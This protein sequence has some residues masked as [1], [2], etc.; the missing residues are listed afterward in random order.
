MLTLALNLV[1]FFRDKVSV[2]FPGWPVTQYVDQAGPELTCLCF[3]RAGNK[4]R[5]HHTQ[6][7]LFSFEKRHCQATQAGL[8]P[9]MLLHRLPNGDSVSRACVTLLSGNL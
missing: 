5:S 4:G 8:K 9:Q 1:N 7:I 2:C 3:P 6:L